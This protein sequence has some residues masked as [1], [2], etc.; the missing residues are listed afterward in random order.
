MKNNM[1]K[2]TNW[3]AGKQIVLFV[4]LVYFY[5]MSFFYCLFGRKKNWILYIFYFSFASL[6]KNGWCLRLQYF[7]FVLCSI[8]QSFN[9]NV[10]LVLDKI[11]EDG[12]TM[13]KGVT[14]STYGYSET[15][16]S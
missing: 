13:E 15:T 10:I 2:G 4:V 3:M 16:R 9:S 7:F 1:K 5:F 6:W 14:R 12:Y 11:K 8:F